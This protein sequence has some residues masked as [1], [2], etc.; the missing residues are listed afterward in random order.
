MLK[1]DFTRKH[2]RGGALGYRWLSP[3]T[4][5][6]SLG[7]GLCCLECV[8]TRAVINQVNGFHLKS[9]QAGDDAEPNG[10]L[11]SA[12][13]L[14]GLDGGKQQGG[15]DS[16]KQ[17]NGL[18]EERQQ[19]DFDGDEQADD[20]D[21]EKRQCGFDGDEKE[22]GLD[23]EERQGGFD[24]DEQA[25]CLDELVDGHWL[26]CD[27][28]NCAQSFLKKWFPQKNGGLQSTNALKEGKKWKSVPEQFA[29][30]VNDN[31]HWIC[32]SN[33]NWRS[34]KVEIFDSLM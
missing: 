10:S 6:T 31:S 11:D 19:D 34:G 26:S 2:R 32:T 3:C 16:D 20:L 30:I 9:F 4:I 5:T 29:Q 13:Q 23:K 1:E 22:N 14:D 21:G 7:K 33:C 15:F 17:E 12:E 25:D 27:A 18:D 24:G 8:Q 28:I